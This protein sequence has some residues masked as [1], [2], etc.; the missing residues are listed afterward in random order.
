MASGSGNAPAWTVKQKEIDDFVDRI[1]RRGA[2]AAFIQG[3]HASGKSTTMVAHILGLVQTRLSGASLVYLMPTLVECV[4]LRDYLASEEFNAQLP[5]QIS[6]RVLEPAPG[7]AIPA[8]SLYV[9]SYTSALQDIR[10]GTFSVFKTGAVVLID[11]EVNPTTDGEML[12]GHVLE[13]ADFSRAEGSGCAVITISTFESPRTE[14]AMDRV[15]GRKPKVIQIPQDFAPVPLRRMPEPW[16]DFAKG[17]AT[18][19]NGTGGPDKMPER[20]VIG[21]E[22]FG[23]VDDEFYSIERP[24]MH[25]EETLADL[26]SKPA[27]MLVA[28]DLCVSLP[29]PGLAHFVSHGIVK[30]QIFDRKTSQI[31]SLARH[32]TRTEI[33]VQQSWLLKSDRPREDTNFH[34]TY[35]DFDRRPL[36][37]DPAGEAYGKDLLWTALNLIHAWPSS[38]PNDLPVKLP[39]DTLGMGEV[40]ARLSILQ[41]IVNEDGQTMGKMDKRGL[42]LVSIKQATGDVIDFHVAYFLACIYTNKGKLSL[43]VRRVIVRIAAILAIGIHTLCTKATPEAE[44]PSLEH[45]RVHC[46]GVGASLAHKGAVWIALGLWQASV[47]SGLKDNNGIYPTIRRGDVNFS[48][49]IAVRVLDLVSALN[50]LFELP[51]TNAELRDTELTSDEILF[52]E[53]Q[54]LWAYLHRV[55]Y[56]SDNPAALPVDVVSLK[57]VTISSDEILDLNVPRVA[58]ENKGKGCFAIYAGLSLSG[59]RYIASGLTIIPLQLIREVKDLTGMPFDQ[60]V[61]THYPLK[62]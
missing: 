21:Q 1:P 34:T 62:P 42:A 26:R 33:L 44:Y 56:L 9:Q 54:L 22:R 15:I 18:R 8:G 52:V 6:D 40:M 43:N 57:D 61:A 45:V 35:E 16:R 17:L 24:S 32:M 58:Q 3:P 55:V 2:S 23:E 4:L 59:S 13:A 39:P 14:A 50:G 11:L 28:S 31:V 41:C 60:A 53:R 12:L 27:S 5:V 51:D 10:N 29:W 37:S 46:V 36:G 19:A 48:I 25:A 38:L 7:E 49:G 30:S 47:Q 20:V